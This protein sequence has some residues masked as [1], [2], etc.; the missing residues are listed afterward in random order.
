M[1]DNKEREREEKDA[2]DVNHLSST[3]KT[4]RVSPVSQSDANTAFLC[5]QLATK[6]GL[7]PDWNTNNINSPLELNFNNPERSVFMLRENTSASSLVNEQTHSKEVTS[8]T[9]T[10]A[11]SNPSDTTVNTTIVEPSD[12]GR[13]R[14]HSDDSSLSD[15]ENSAHKPASKIPKTVTFHFQKGKQNTSSNN[16]PTPTVE[17]DG[18]DTPSNTDDDYYIIQPAETFWLEA[19]RH[20]RDQRRNL[21]RAVALEDQV[22]DG[23][24]PLSAY[25]L[26]LAQQHYE[27]PMNSE[28][29]DLA[30][31]QARDFAIL[32]ARLLREKAASDGCQANYFLDTVR[33]VYLDKGNDDFP[34]AEAKAVAIAALG[35]RREKDNQAKML[36]MQERSRPANAL[37]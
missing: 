19:M 11:R 12:K 24:T 22:N 1:D 36:D 34:K 14:I 3:L 31:T 23:L 10:D 2:Q 30:H 18:E 7:S 5:S 17:Q 4:V 35:G 26:Q 25:G 27:F 15:I 32:E 28:L 21:I 8:P 16:K 33:K 29:V 13:K 20:L 37:E 9:N 6:L